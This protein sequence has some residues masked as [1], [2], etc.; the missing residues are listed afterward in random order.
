MIT[1]HV[2]LDAQYDQAPEKKAVVVHA[3]CVVGDPPP[4][5][6]ARIPLG[7]WTFKVDPIEGTIA[8]LWLSANPF[9]GVEPVKVLRVS[10]A[11][12]RWLV[13]EVIP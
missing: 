10:A 11:G 5:K 12:Y 4:D 9:G 6:Q 8:E 7:N 2:Y 13:P 3:G 1:K